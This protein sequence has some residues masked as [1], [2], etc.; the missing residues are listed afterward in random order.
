M[1]KRN[2]LLFISYVH[3]RSHKYPIWTYLR[4][5]YHCLV[6]LLIKD[7]PD[8]PEDTS[9][10]ESG[11]HQSVIRSSD[12]L[13]LPL[14]HYVHLPDFTEDTSF[15]E[16][17]QRQSVIRSSDNLNL[18][19]AHYVHLPDF[20]EDASFLES[21]QHQSVVWSSDDL[22]LPLAH[23]VHFLPYLSLKFSNGPFKSYI[24]GSIS[25]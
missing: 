18:P 7:L 20:T 14:A 3:L 21:G 11:Q 19:L 6:C 4:I 24:Q 22:N 13:S 17:G 8:F 5:C 9:F 25:K 1:S 23:Y 15:L 10:L 16:S 12:N 2:D